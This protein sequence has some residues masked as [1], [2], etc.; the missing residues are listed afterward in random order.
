[1]TFK[2]YPIYS[3]SLA[4]V[5][6]VSISGCHQPERDI[7]VAPPNELNTASLDSVA[8]NDI[9]PFY[10]NA[11]VDTLRYYRFK[12]HADY[13]VSISLKPVSR[14][15]EEP[16][17]VK[18][19]LALG[20]EGADA[21]L[22]R[23]NDCPAGSPGACIQALSLPQTGTYVVAQMT[24]AE[25]S[26]GPVA[27]SVD[28]KDTGADSAPHRGV[29][30]DADQEPSLASDGRWFLYG[31]EHVYLIGMDM[32]SLVAQRTSPDNG[33]P[34]WDGDYVRVLDE[35]AA[36]GI[37]KLRLW[38]NNWFLGADNVLQP[39]LRRANG[40]Y[41]LDQ[42]DD[43]YWARLRKFTLEAKRRR[44]FIEYCL[45]S[46][47]A[48][49]GKW[50]KKANFWN[51]A[52]NVSGAFEDIDS[53][54]GAYEEFFRN[55][56]GQTTTSGHDLHYYQKRLF[57]KAAE[58]IGVFG[59]VFFQ[60]M[61]EP[62]DE[63][64]IFE[65]TRQIAAMIHNA[66]YLSSV[67]TQAASDGVAIMEYWDEPNID[68]LGWHV[69][70]GSPHMIND[71]LHGAHNRG[72]ILQVNEGFNIRDAS[73]LDALTREAWAWALS[74]GSYGFFHRDRDFASV[75][76]TVWDDHIQV[77]STLRAVMESVR[78]WDMSPVDPHGYEYDR[79]VSQAPHGMD[80]QVFANPGSEY[81]VYLW[82]SR[83][84][85]FWRRLATWNRPLI[86]DLEYGAY[87]VT[88]IAAR[89]G[90]ELLKSPV[91]GG[92]STRI[93]APDRV[94]WKGK[95]GLLMIVRRTD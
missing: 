61:N 83:G 33:D 21:W 19:F 32:H 95:Y 73:T 29:N 23:S 79:L 25:A 78:Y 11:G 60:V 70:A 20:E 53:S 69:Y 30:R 64:A 82:D 51:L 34:N 13:I 91:E 9:L 43:E 94:R 77:A 40:L 15:S 85:S 62:K 89:N 93:F 3:L 56:F 72:R 1:M 52:N 76:D 75:G 74:G 68:I 44:I 8:C 27:L 45:F 2:L 81:I 36:A 59:N 92:V 66:G 42:W 26:R 87:E 88:W 24:Y 38:A 18:A 67:E 46:Q 54:D 10:P 4:F 58:E 17:D 35:L 49:D 37:N 28:C 80:W 57:E 55:A 14:L 31:G 5:I 12:G 16:H 6:S 22:M 41:E 63:E 48:D 86:M 84:N 50:T 90:E 47:Y 65:W 7:T 39:F 71:A